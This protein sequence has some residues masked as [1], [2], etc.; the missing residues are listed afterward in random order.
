MF[1]I[2]SLSSPPPPFISFYSSL[3]SPSLCHLQSVFP[4]SPHYHNPPGCLSS[5]QSSFLYLTL[6]PLSAPIQGRLFV[7]VISGFHY[8]SFVSGSP[9][10]FLF[11][12]SEFVRIFFIQICSLSPSL[13]IYLNNGCLSFHSSFSTIVSVYFPFSS[14]PNVYHFYLPTNSL[15]KVICKF[16]QKPILCE[17]SIFRLIFVRLFSFLKHIHPEFAWALEETILPFKVSPGMICVRICLLLNRKKI[18]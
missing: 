7:G 17:S 10:A 2:Y 8:C 1:W 4:L 9:T 14:T 3:F 12:F 5:T 15:V 18:I 16:K 11:F 6:R 13:T